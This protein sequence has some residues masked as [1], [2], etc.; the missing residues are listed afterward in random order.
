[1]PTNNTYKSIPWKYS[2]QL[3][4]LDSLFDVETPNYVV[5]A[6]I[7]NCDEATV[8]TL[9]RHDDEY[10]TDTEYHCP[11]CGNNHFYNANHMLSESTWYDNIQ[12][13]FTD[14]DL[15]ALKPKISSDA[16][17]CATRLQTVLEIPFAFD[18]VRNKLHYKD[19]IL[20][21]TIVN[22]I[23]GTTEQIMYVD[24]GISNTTDT[25]SSSFYNKPKPTDEQINECE[26]LVDC[27]QALLEHLKANLPNDMPQAVLQC[28]TLDEAVVFIAHPH[29]LDIEFVYWDDLAYLPRDRELAIL[30]ALSFVSNHR[31]EKSFKR[32]L[33]MHYNRKMNTASKFDFGF[34]NLVSKHIKDV[35][36]AR[37]M[38]SINMKSQLHECNLDMVEAYMAYLC[39]SYKDIRIERLFRKYAVDTNYFF[40]DTVELFFGYY[41]SGEP[42]PVTH[43]NML[44]LHD[45]F[46]RYDELD[47]IKYLSTLVFTYE[48]RHMSACGEFD[49]FEI[50]LPLVGEDLLTWGRQLHNCLT[51]YA[52]RIQERTTAVYGLFVDNKLKIAIEIRDGQIVQAS[53]KYNQR[54]SQDELEMIRGWFEG[55]LGESHG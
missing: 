3:S 22:P 42:L 44:E 11:H 38:I 36:V 18:L 10:Q 1:M 29:L 25:W 50:R 35:N 46:L 9:I 21:E 39:T 45:A 5:E 28:R 53:R 7:C 19:K 52:Q 41:Q 48:P 23:E 33:Y 47:D 17:C 34:I 49:G 37:R 4:D 8:E 32:E 43:C 26:L 2:T 16:E 24:F 14:E 30:E 12:N 20:Y 51:T 27:K 40:R 15:K 31:K 6:Y 55:G 54:P 13:I